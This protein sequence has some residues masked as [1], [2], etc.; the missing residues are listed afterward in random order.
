MKILFMYFFL[1]KNSNLH[2]CY[3]F[4]SE[5][6]IKRAIKLNKDMHLVIFQ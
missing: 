4:I 3:S 1:F 2:I 5:N 6:G